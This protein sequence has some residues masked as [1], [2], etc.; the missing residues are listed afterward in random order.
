MKYNLAQIAE[1]GYRWGDCQAIAYDPARTSIFAPPFLYNLYVACK[2]S[3]AGRRSDRG[4]GIL[5]PTFCGFRD[6]G[7]E[8]VCS[9]LHTQKLVILGEWRS[10]EPYAF[11]SRFDPLGFCWL[12]TAIA[13]G[14]T[15]RSAFGA[16]AFFREAWRTPQQMV[17]TMIGISYLFVEN[18]LTT[19][20][21][22]R[23]ADNKL[24]ARWMEKF[25]F[26]DVGTVPQY[27]FRSSTGELE[28][29]TVSTLARETF[30]A[31][32]S[33]ALEKCGELQEE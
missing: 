10:N 18:N 4:T 28:S 19:L 32:L 6:L 15:S 9:Y 11:G 24:T 33:Q 2:D 25:G 13:Q 14:A 7:H 26:S 23:Y 21:G 12:S 27:L 8:A 17:L 29:A 22:I 3:S 20:H 1:L 30:S 5:E 16:Y 31:I